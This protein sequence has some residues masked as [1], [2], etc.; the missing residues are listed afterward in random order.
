MIRSNA[1]SSAVGEIRSRHL[2]K[3]AS[4][5]SISFDGKSPAARRVLLVE[6]HPLKRIT[7]Q[8]A[9]AGLAE[10]LAVFRILKLMPIHTNIQY[11]NRMNKNP[12]GEAVCVR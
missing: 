3:S 8:A 12:P 2:S 4:R 10:R 5:N 7:K 6:E 9:T 1:S 11:V